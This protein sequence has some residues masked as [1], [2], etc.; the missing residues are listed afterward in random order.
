VLYGAIFV[1]IVSG[2]IYSLCLDGRLFYNDERCYHNLAYNLARSG[3]YSLDGQNPTAYRPPGYPLLLAPFLRLNCG[4]P[5]LRILNYLAL[6]G[7]LGLVYRMLR[8]ESG[9]LAAWLGVVMIPA[10]PV[11]FYTAGRLYPQII[12]ALLFLW[13]IDLLTGKP[14]TLRRLAVCGLFFGFLILIVPLFV[15]TL[16]ILGAWLLF[17][18]RTGLKGVAVFLI[19]AFLMTGIWSVRNYLV[20]DTFVFVASNC[21]TNLLLGNSENSSSI[22]GSNVNIDRYKI[23]TYRIGMDEIEKDKFY[24]DQALEWIRENKFKALV[25]YGRKVVHYFHCSNELATRGEASRYCNPIMLL[26]Y[27]PLLLLLVLR[28]LSARRMK[29]TRFELLLVILYLSSAFYHAIFF[30]RIRFR[31]PFD[32]LLIMLAALF[33]QQLISRRLPSKSQES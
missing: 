11:L 15:F 33:V 6:A 26:T 21:G 24:R 1:I 27:G 23:E 29:F 20:F 8:R 25:L 12:A 14:L 2:S 10:Y 3:I 19:A 31:L 28:L 13:I 18:R 4:V 22:S 17:D 32:L 9:D 5:L 16:I 7:C 30:T